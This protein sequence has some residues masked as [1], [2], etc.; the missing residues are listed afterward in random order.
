[1]W[2][3]LLKFSGEQDSGNILCQGYLSHRSITCG[4][5]P[6]EWKCS[7]VI[8]LFKQGERFDLNNYRPISVIPI[9][10]KVLERIV[11]NQLY[12]YLTVNNLSTIPA[13][14]GLYSDGLDPCPG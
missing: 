11:Y 2:P 13:V 8:P 10:A 6:D 7:K 12:G 14:F 4:I 5:L 9:I 1:M 3:H